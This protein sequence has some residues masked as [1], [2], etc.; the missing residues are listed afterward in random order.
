MR[1]F[2]A[3]ALGVLG[4]LAIAGSSLGAATDAHIGTPE[5]HFDGLWYFGPEQ[6]FG[7]ADFRDEVRFDAG[8]CGVGAFVSPLRL[9]SGASTTK[10]FA[11]YMQ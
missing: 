4:A 9:A 5:Q 3:A 6:H 1:F 8:H 7:R 2:R 10:T 11:C